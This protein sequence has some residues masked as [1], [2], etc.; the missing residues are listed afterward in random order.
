MLCTRGFPIFSGEK[1][2]CGKHFPQHGTAAQGFL[3]VRQHAPACGDMEQGSGQPFHRGFFMG[4]RTEC[5]NDLAR[6]FSRFRP[7]PIHIGSDAADRRRHAESLRT[8]SRSSTRLNNGTTR[9]CTRPPTACAPS[10]VPRC[11]A[12]LQ[13]RVGLVV[14]VPYFAKRGGPAVGWGGGRQACSAPRHPRCGDPNAAI[15][16]RRIQAFSL[17]QCRPHLCP[18]RPYAHLAGVVDA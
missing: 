3:P 7:R 5:V 11:V 14:S 1:A 4:K 9:R 16:D 15:D 10:L 18:S 6:C 17:A 8:D 13:R 2:C 12:S